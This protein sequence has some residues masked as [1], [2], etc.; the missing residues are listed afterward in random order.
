MGGVRVFRQFFDDFFVGFEF[1]R[2]GGAL[3]TKGHFG[4]TENCAPEGIKTLLIAVSTENF[5]FGLF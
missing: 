3:V 5:V 1:W 4:I 2:G